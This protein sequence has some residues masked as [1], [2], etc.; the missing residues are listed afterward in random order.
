VNFGFY[1]E[2]LWRLRE[3]VPR[4]RPEIWRERTWLLHH[5]NDPS[6]TSVLIQLFMTKHKMAVIRHPPYS[7]DLAPCDFFFFSKNE[8]EADRTPF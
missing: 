5:E 8:I 3:N 4:R 7:R 6:H 1:W 2:V